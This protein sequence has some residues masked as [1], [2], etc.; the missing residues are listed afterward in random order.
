MGGCGTQQPPTSTVS[1]IAGHHPNGRFTSPQM[2]SS[3]RLSQ[4]TVDRSR[5][6]KKLSWEQIRSLHMHE[7]RL[8]EY[9][10]EVTHK[11]NESRAMIREGRGSVA[12]DARAI[13]IPLTNTLS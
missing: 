3:E 8:G 10:C 2:T 1:S 7:L 13:L 5:S 6:E 11:I 4:L 12:D 9:A